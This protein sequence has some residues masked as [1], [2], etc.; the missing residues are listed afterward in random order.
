MSH[1]I[2][3]DSP[4]GVVLAVHV[5]PGAKRTEYAGLHGE[6]MKFRVAAPPAE[7]AANEALCSFLA[8]QFGLPKGSVVL[9]SGLSSRRKRVLLKGV[10]GRRVKEV[11]YPEAS[12]AC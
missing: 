5:Q 8:E 4:E 2:V 6:A 11:F 3:Q 1:A 9:R 7:G 10:S 12:E